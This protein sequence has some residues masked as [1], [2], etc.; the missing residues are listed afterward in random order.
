MI[1]IR[2]AL[3]LAA[4]SRARSDVVRVAP[5]V[6]VRRSGVRRRSRSTFATPAGKRVIDNVA[7]VGV[8][9]DAGVAANP[10][11]ASEACSYSVEAP[12]GDLVVSA[13]GLSARDRPYV[14]ESDSCGY[15]V[16]QSVQNHAG[17]GEFSDAANPDSVTRH[18]V[19]WLGCG[20]TSNA[21]EV[22]L[23]QRCRPIIGEDY[24]DDVQPH[25]SLP[26]GR[27]A[28]RHVRSAAP[29]AIAG[30][31]GLVEDNKRRKRRS[32]DGAQPRC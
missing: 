30:Q 8:P 29:E 22:E 16:N 23:G 25:A 5:S 11:S 24:F 7:I 21:S 19:R 17:P 3:M 1:Q 6:Q 15:P 28:G 13:A 20:Q 32:T 9:N 26:S 12:E 10:C 31:A 4:R 27:R 2:R 18:A 14:S